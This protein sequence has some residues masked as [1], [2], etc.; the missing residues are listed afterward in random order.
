MG[1]PIRRNEAQT[2]AALGPRR[3]GQR[4][5]APIR[6]LTVGLG[7]ITAANASAA[8]QALTMGSEPGIATAGVSTSSDGNLWTPV[9]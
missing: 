5:G 6:P 7:A 9:Q 4:P 1:E 8:Y 2:V 3:A